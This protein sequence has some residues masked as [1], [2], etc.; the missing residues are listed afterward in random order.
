DLE[1]SHARLLDRDRRFE[2][3][4]A[5][6]A[7]RLKGRR[8]R[9]GQ[10]AP[11]GYLRSAIPTRVNGGLAATRAGCAGGRVVRLTHPLRLERGAVAEIGSRQ[12]HVQQQLAVGA[13]LGHVWL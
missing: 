4:L 11:A 2:P 10:D 13:V 8:T 7:E 3:G 12:H 5:D 6:G 1:D 9:P